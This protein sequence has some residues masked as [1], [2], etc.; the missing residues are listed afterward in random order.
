M[1]TVKTRFT[2]IRIIIGQ[3]EPV[4]LDV[5]VKNPG[6]EEVL[7]TV[8]VRVPPGLGL[9]P[10]C[11]SRE[12]R[13]RLDYVPAEGEKTASFRIYPKFNVTPGEYTVSVTLLTHPGRYD[14]VSMEKEY[15]TILRVLE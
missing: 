6:D 1:L 5:I 3:K 2:P 11:I 7:S 13:Q 9:D 10:S 8:I 12:K 4:N 14:K 15:R